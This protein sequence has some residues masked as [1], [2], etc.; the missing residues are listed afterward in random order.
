MTTEQHADGFV[1]QQRT[2]L[3]FV[4]PETLDEATDRLSIL[5]SSIEDITEQLG[6]MLAR[7]PDQQAWTDEQ[8]V[9]AKRA[10]AARKY[11]CRDADRIRLWITEY[12]EELRREEIAVATE[13]TSKSQRERWGVCLEGA[14]ILQLLAIKG[15]D[16]GD[17]GRKH[18]EYVDRIVPA[19]AQEWWVKEQLPHVIARHQRAERRGE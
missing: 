9:W 6:A 19:D 5:Q 10:R 3:P 15:I 12:K 18:V 4:P 16:I 11:R 17:D 7:E 14:A 13:R 1:E 2:E 8:R